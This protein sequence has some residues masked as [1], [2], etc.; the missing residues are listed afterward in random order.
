MQ[1]VPSDTEDDL[2]LDFE[3]EVLPPCPRTNR[4]PKSGLYL[5][6]WLLD[7]STRK[8]LHFLYSDWYV[9]LPSIL[10]L[11]WSKPSHIVCVVSHTLEI[12]LSIVNFSDYEEIE[13][14]CKLDYDSL[15]F[16]QQFEMKLKEEYD[17]GN[18]CF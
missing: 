15:Y 17:S 6:P 3:P 8:W 5:T 1:E 9:F 2:K 16:N 10:S 13:D 7:F 12:K 18:L 11:S 14:L 4:S